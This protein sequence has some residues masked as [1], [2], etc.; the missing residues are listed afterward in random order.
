MS[1]EEAKYYKIAVMEIFNF[2]LLTFRGSLND[3]IV[4]IFNSFLNFLRNTAH[5]SMFD[6]SDSQ[7]FRKKEVVQNLK[8]ICK[9]NSK[10]EEILEKGVLSIEQNIQ[11]PYIST[12]PILFSM[13]LS[14]FT[15]LNQLL[16]SLSTTLLRQ[17]F[18]C[19]LPKAKKHFDQN[20]SGDKIIKNSAEESSVD[21]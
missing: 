1:A 15:N 6:W 19:V 7:G 20:E 5:S 11:D 4:T 10:I 13:T 14:F 12:T 21:S 16:P 8:Q 18:L 17:I 9:E 2:L 3:H